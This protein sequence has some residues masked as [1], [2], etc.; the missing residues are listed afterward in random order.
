MSSLWEEEV[1]LDYLLYH[2]GIELILTQ[3]KGEAQEVFPDLTKH[4]LAGIVDTVDF[5]MAQFED[6]DDVVRP[7][8]NG[9]NQT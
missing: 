9:C 7:G 3:A 2:A 5:T 8:C 6:T 1:L 4:Q